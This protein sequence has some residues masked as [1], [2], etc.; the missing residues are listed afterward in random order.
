MKYFSLLLLWVYAMGL[1]E[2]WAATAERG[3][4]I[5]YDEPTVNTDSTPLDDLLGTRIYTDVFTD[6]Q[7][8]T[9][10]PISATAKTGGGHISKDLCIPIL[11]DATATHIEV[12]V[13]AVDEAG[14][15]SAPAPVSPIIHPVAGTPDCTVLPPPPTNNDPVISVILHD[16]IDVDTDKPGLQ[17]YEGTTVTYSVGMSD[18]DGDDVAW[19]WLYTQD[20]GV[21]ISFL[22][23]AALPVANAVIDYQANMAPTTYEWIIRGDDGN[24][25][26]AERRFSTEIVSAPPDTTAPLQPQNVQIQ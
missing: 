18:V 20:G 21:E 6:G 7:L 25:G 10:L 15:E 3:F 11:D 4:T 5:E 17:V 1:G 13:T 16:A 26:T 14:N 8:G 23:G 12:F 9:F 22:S 2:A 24:G 19:Q